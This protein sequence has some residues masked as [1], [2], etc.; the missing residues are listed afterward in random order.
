MELVGNS[1]SVGSEALPSP[2]GEAG[3]PVDKGS[4]DKDRTSRGI[5]AQCW[6]LAKST[7]NHR[8]IAQKGREV[9][10]ESQLESYRVQC[11]RCGE[12]LQSLSTGR[13]E[14]EGWSL[15]RETM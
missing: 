2:G 3:S 15:S 5:P 14:H 4:Q 13:M 9:S 10:M 8:P 6:A 1:F 11:S 12:G 7:S